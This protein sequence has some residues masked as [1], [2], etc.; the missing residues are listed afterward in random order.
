MRYRTIV[1]WLFAAMFIAGGLFNIVT[2]QRNGGSYAAFG[3]TALWGWLEWLW[4]SFVMPNIGWL[5]AVLGVGQVAAGTGLTLGGRWARAG[6]LAILAFLGFILVLGYGFPTDSPGADFL[7]NRLG[8]LVLAGLL[9][10]L[11]RAALITGTVRC[12]HDDSRRSH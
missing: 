8:T 7:T 9:S 4:D 3:D 10:P 1:R 2:G 11:A 12:H 6:A 5:T